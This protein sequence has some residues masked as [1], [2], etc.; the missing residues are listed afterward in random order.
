MF[1]NQYTELIVIVYWHV[2]IRGQYKNTHDRYKGMYTSI[3]MTSSVHRQNGYRCLIGINRESSFT[4]MPMSTH[5]Y[6]IYTNHRH[7]TT[8][9]I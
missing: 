8:L 2:P 7:T 6:N 9:S 3:L 1:M 5:G 4:G